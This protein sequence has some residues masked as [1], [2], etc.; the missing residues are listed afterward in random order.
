MTSSPARKALVSKLVFSDSIARD[1]LLDVT[2]TKTWLIALLCDVVARVGAGKV[3]ITSVRGDHGADPPGAVHGH[4]E[5]WAFDCAPVGGDWQ[6][7]IDALLASPYCWTIGLGGPAAQAL[8]V[9]ARA[10]AQPLQIVFLDNQQPH[11]HAQAGNMYG[12][13]DRRLAS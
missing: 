4:E 9:H 11:V 10:I 3:L 1:D 5:G 6:G 12:E 7:L 13:G 8:V 2:R